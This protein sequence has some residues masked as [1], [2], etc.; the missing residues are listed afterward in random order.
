ML[1]MEKYFTLFCYVMGKNCRC[2]SSNAI[3][4]L[5]VIVHVTV[6][7][8]WSVVDRIDSIHGDSDC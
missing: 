6:V 3:S 8:H 5:N 1:T 2:F 4:S 7:L